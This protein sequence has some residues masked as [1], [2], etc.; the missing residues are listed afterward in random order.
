MHEEKDKIKEEHL[1]DVNSYLRLLCAIRPYSNL[2]RQ[3]MRSILYRK[4]VRPLIVPV[5]RSHKERTVVVQHLPVLLR[6]DI[7]ED[8]AVN[9]YEIETIF[10]GIICPIR[11]IKNM[12]CILIYLYFVI[13]VPNVVHT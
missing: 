6:Y 8:R 13:I 5:V 9:A 7:Q 1:E 4:R 2:V 11:T 3:S 12:Q 10:D